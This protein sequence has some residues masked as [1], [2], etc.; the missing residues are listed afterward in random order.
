M[1]HRAT[2]VGDLAAGFL[3]SGK[4][5]RVTR[6]FQSSAYVR[7]GEDFLLLLWGGLRSPMTINVEGGAATRRIRVGD[8]CK[9]SR[10][11]VALD[12]VSIDVEGADVFRSALLD[13]REVSLPGGEQLRKGVTV[14]R[15][16]YDVSPPGPTLNKDRALKTFAGSMLVPLASGESAG[17]YSH[18]GYL[19]L[20]GRGGGF[21]PAGDDFLGGLL[22]TFNFV[23]RC[24][25]SRQIRI[26]LELLRGK[27]VPESANVL[28]HSAR[29]YVDESMERLIL[30]SLDGGRGF[31]DELIEVAHRGHTSGM[32]MSLGVL[33]CEAAVADADSGGGILEDCLDILW[34]P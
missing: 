12:S 27:T 30:R 32:D 22:A 31:S 21:T 11:G 17:V 20:V 26:P 28:F 23:A 14:I 18:A 8:R 29:G 7:S 1:N 24:R 9:L 19:P 33:L 4:C 34:R 15:S 6:V 13:R 2:S 16:L 25:K 10:K 3:S 5:G